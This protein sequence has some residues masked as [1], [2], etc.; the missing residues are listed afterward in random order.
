MTK[1]MKLTTLHDLHRYVSLHDSVLNS[2]LML[3]EAKLININKCFVIKV[4][5]WK[6]LPFIYIACHPIF[7]CWIFLFH[8]EILFKLAEVENICVVFIFVVAFFS[9][10]TCFHYS[11]HIFQTK[12]KVYIPPKKYSQTSLF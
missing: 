5:L 9:F 4:K 3:I 8:N 12:L 11:F 6:G 10:A 1:E 7:L 2:L